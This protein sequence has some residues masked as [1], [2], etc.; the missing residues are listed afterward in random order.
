MGFFVGFEVVLEVFE[1]ELFEVREWFESLGFGLN[2]NEETDFLALYCA[3]SYLLAKLTISSK[4]M[5]S[6][7]CGLTITR[8]WEFIPSKK[9]LLATNSVI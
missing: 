8:S 5:E 7:H 3:A 1:F 2:E 4:V 9:P 6:G